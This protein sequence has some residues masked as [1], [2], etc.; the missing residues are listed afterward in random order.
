MKI[1]CMDL[2]C[3]ESAQALNFKKKKTLHWN[4]LEKTCLFV[5]SKEDDKYPG[6]TKNL[7]LLVEC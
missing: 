6:L 4:I 3:L 5:L 2:N 1:Y 7:I